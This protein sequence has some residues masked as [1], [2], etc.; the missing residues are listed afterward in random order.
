MS[1]YRALLIE[2]LMAD[3]ALDRACRKWSEAGDVKEP[4][5]AHAIR[6][7]VAELD[8]AIIRKSEALDAAHVVFEEPE[9]V[10]P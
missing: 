2:V 5:R 8:A 10:R 1:D 7:A 3:A 4:Y 9:E 6:A